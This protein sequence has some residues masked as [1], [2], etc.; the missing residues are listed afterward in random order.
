MRIEPDQRGLHPPA[1]ECSKLAFADR[2]KF[3]GDPKFVDSADR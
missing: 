2:D 3:Y 1:V